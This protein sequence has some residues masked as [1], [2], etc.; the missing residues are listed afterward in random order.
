M[1]YL[2]FVV[3][4]VYTLLSCTFMTQY[5]RNGLIDREGRGWSYTDTQYYFVCG[6]TFLIAPMC[7][8]F[9]IPY[10]CLKLV[11]YAI[12]LIGETVVQS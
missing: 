9:I 4:I 11:Y 2:V 1:E 8:W 3:G 12:A 7:G 10:E 5:I 6:L